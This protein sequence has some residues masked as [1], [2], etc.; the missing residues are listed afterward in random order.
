MR[1]PQDVNCGDNFYALGYKRGKLAVCPIAKEGRGAYVARAD[2]NLKGQ[3]MKIAASLLVL[4]SL[5]SAC[6]SQTPTSGMGAAHEG[7]ETAA[8]EALEGPG[9]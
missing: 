5:L 7:N 3:I 2:T 4:L 1:H 6:D 8:M 9:Q